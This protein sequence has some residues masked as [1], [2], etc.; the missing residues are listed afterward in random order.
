MAESVNDRIER[1]LLWTAVLLLCALLPL[2]RAAPAVPPA[3]M[4]SAEWPREW[5]GRPLRPMSLSDVEQRFAQRFPGRI[6]RL[7]DGEHVLVV[8]EVR[9]ATRMLHP[10]ADCYRGL[11]YEIANARLERDAGQRLWRCFVAQRGGQKLRVCERIVNA[12]GVAHTDT[13]D[14]FWAAALGH[15]QGPWQAITIARPL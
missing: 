12:D 7:T 14:W 6:A 8:R 4:P 10:A 13:S 3:P 9:E 11:G 2:W 1:K 5:E 15:T